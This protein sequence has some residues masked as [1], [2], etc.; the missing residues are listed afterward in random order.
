MYIEQEDAVSFAA[1][2]EVTLMDW[3][4][5]VVDNQDVSSPIKSLNFKLHLAGD[6]KATSKKITWLAVTESAPLLSVILKDY[7]YLITKRRIEDSDEWTDYINPVTEFRQE[8]FADPNLRDLKKGDT[9]QFERKGFY[10]VDKVASGDDLMELIYVP[11]GKASSIALKAAPAAPKKA[12]KVVV[13]ANGLA[14]PISNGLPDLAPTEA[15][16]R[17]IDSRGLPIPVK[18]KVSQHVAPDGVR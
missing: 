9:I 6:F 16:D 10:I 7:D 3:G 15:Q 1:N 4:N 11:D 8:A 12:E 5:A 13:E 17:I 18:T 2:E 14:P